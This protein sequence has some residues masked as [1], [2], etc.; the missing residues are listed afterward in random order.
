MSDSETKRYREM[1]DLDRVR[2]DR[3][4]RLLKEGLAVGVD[5]CCNCQPQLNESI[6]DP[7][8]K[9]KHEDVKQEKKTRESVDVTE[10]KK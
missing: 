5:H 8:V 6:C 2:Y 10:E 3:H 9:A 7:S 4:R 1:S